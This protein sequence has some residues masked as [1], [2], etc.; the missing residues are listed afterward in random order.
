MFP[1]PLQPL[2][3]ASRTIFHFWMY[4]GTTHAEPCLAATR[5]GGY[6]IHIIVCRRVSM[7]SRYSLALIAFRDVHRDIPMF[8]QVIP[9]G[10]V[11]YINPFTRK[12]VVLFNGIDPAS[13]TDQQIKSIPSLLEG[14][15]TKLIFDPNYSSFPD[16]EREYTYSDLSDV[17][18]LL[19]A[20]FEG[21]TFVFLS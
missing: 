5:H 1:L 19:G 15:A 2:S 7:Y 18:A 4:E 8:E 16:W 14:G 17:G 11:G 21:R 10:S 12:F 9:V 3:F 6:N 20:W 13:S